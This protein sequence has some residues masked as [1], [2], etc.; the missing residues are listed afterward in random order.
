MRCLIIEDSPAKLLAVRDAINAA[1]AG[2]TCE[3]H[4]ADSLSNAVRLLS[5]TPY[6]IIFLDLML[7]Y[8]SDGA[9]DS[10]AGLELLRQIRRDD[11]VNRLSRVIGISA[12]PDEILEHRTQFDKFGVLIIEF[13]PDGTWKAAVTRVVSE[14]LEVTA[15]PISVDFVVVVAL[16]KER[17]G[18]NA[19]DAD[20]SEETVVRGVSIQFLKTRS[21]RPAL[22]VLIRMRQMGLVAAT[23]EVAAALSLFDTRI[24]AMSGICAG[25]PGR[26]DLGQLIV[27]SPA[28]EYQA[29]KWAENGFEIAPYQIPLRPKTRAVID[30]ALRDQAFLRSLELDLDPH[31]RRP[32]VK[33]SPCLGPVATGS[34]VIADGNKLKHVEQ[35]HRK[36]AA[37]DMETFG[38]YYAVHEHFNQ[39]IHFFAVKCVVDLAD[40]GKGDEL[41]QY[42]CAVSAR[43][44]LHLIEA[45]RI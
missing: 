32:P 39:D 8:L 19:T 30:V 20:L 40:A 24:V 12:F 9:A 34:A 38:L 5:S 31:W 14:I 21:D 16:E 26:T 36:L 42:G 29:G 3:I 17:N 33:K 45:L 41:H 15:F 7:P 28:W 22:G 27:G 1:T 43:A 44:A 4:D 13:G 6:D 23:F 11:S 35:Q 2:E 25:F 10:R 37:L 18:Y